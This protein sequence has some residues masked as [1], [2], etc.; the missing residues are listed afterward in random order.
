MDK[1]QNEIGSHQFPNL[2]VYC[3]L[4]W[5]AFKSLACCD[6]SILEEERPDGGATL[7]SQCKDLGIWS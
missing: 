5:A 2:G 7:E 4:S 6:V 1:I 3:E